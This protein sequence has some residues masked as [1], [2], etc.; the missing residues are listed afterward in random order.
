MTALSFP[1][2]ALVLFCMRKSPEQWHRWRNE[3]GAQMLS[4]WVAAWY[5][6]SFG[7]R[8]I[9]TTGW[10]GEQEKATSETMSLT[11]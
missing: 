1:T 5:S 11:H 3:C 4:R 8:F 2:D 9:E 6:C 7:I 10:T